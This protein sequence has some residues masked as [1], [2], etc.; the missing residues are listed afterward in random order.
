[1]NRV[2]FEGKEYVISRVRNGVT[3]LVSVL[4]GTLKIVNGIITPT[5]KS[6]HPVFDNFQS[7]LSRKKE[8][9]LELRKR[10]SEQTF[11]AGPSKSRKQKT[12]TVKKVKTPGG[13]K[14]KVGAEK[15]AVTVTYAPPEIVAKLRL[16]PTANRRQMCEA[17]GLRAT[18]EML[19]I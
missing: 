7:F 17:M 8:F 16:L 3:E 5:Y 9:L 11:K 13:R 18:D 15:V 14:K 19:G 1:M 6:H 2:N 10:R 12:P 4:D